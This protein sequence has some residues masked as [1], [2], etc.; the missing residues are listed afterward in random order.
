MTSLAV[1][2]SPVPRG[3][4]TADGGRLMTAD[5]APSGDRGWL[6]TVSARPV[7]TAQ[8]LAT[9]GLLAGPLADVRLPLARV[10][11]AGQGAAVEGGKASAA[12]D[13]NV[14]TDGARRRRGPGRRARR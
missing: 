2:T 1:G 3:G 7:V 9:V 12:A 11:P 10:S 14:G 13:Q 4:R 5:S 8:A 6:F